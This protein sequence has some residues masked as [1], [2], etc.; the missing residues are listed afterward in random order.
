MG[1]LEV[2]DRMRHQGRSLRKKSGGRKRA[3]RNKRKFEL[4]REAIDTI[5]GPEKKK[6]VRGRGGNVKINLVRIEYANITD[7]K[8]HKTERIKILDIEDNPADKDYARRKIITKGAIINT[9]KGMAKV[10]SRPGQ[11][12]QINVVLIKKE[13]E[14]ENN[15]K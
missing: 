7:P 10:T 4:G 11:D 5:I 9:E 13:E 15:Q 3:H 8:T 14:R 6:K 2:G 1:I 12:G